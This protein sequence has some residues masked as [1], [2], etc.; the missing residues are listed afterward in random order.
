[1]VRP[2][3]F[4]MANPYAPLLGRA[5]LI[6]VCAL[7]ASL[8]AQPTYAVPPAMLL[9]GLAALSSVPLPKSIPTL[10][11]PVAEALVAPAIIGALGMRGELF[12]PY[13]LAPIVITG[14]L[15]GARIAAVTAVASTAMLVIGASASSSAGSQL[16]AATDAA[17]WGPMVLAV[18]LL[19]A[20]SRRIR[21]PAEPSVEP[22]YAD[23]HRLLSELHV[24]ARHLS[25]G[26]DPQ[27][28]ARALLEEIS[29]A[30][31]AR[32][33]TVLVRSPG[34]L[35]VPLVG[36]EPPPDAQSAVHDAWITGETVRRSKREA[37][38]VAM[39]VMMGVRVVALVVLIL[40]RGKE[41]FDDAAMRGCQSA[42]ERSGPRL[43]T[44]MLFDDVRRL[45]TEDERVRVAREIHD[46]IAQ[47][48]AS[49]GYLVDD[50]A[51][52]ADEG[53]SKRLAELRE[54][55]GTM[56]TELRLSI[57]DLR[58]G[59]DDSLGLG[60]AV[61]E[62]VQRVG[63]QS[64][65]VVH[66][67]LDEAPHRLPTAVEVELLRILQEAVTNVRRHARASNLWL[68]LIV[69]PP[70]ARLAIADDGR[71]LQSPRPDSMGI[72]GMQE[73]ARRIG[74]RL[75][76]GPSEFGGTL[77]EVVVD[78]IGSQQ[79]AGRPIVAAH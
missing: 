44:A 60:T 12:R 5:C 24:V 2:R 52:D 77:V 21:R 42:V 30:V 7:L 26:L 69:D 1:M 37:T 35:F 46:G 56:V 74:G 51:Q 28:L 14:V 67:L 23:A 62:Y 31:E 47:D 41:T 38:V 16:S 10:L 15:G 20:W 45:A 8:K 72:T 17:A 40:T 73:R 43:A 58:T 34:G 27:T 18:G 70:R 65:L 63:S 68:T 75:H 78:G 39:P 76:I 29:T 50:I 57:F 59:V 36:E 13:L 32:A 53:T 64:G 49:V 4:T 48:L 25:L 66:V 9:L 6:L 33:A 55:L 79:T 22:A 19:A 61:S 3:L 71:G 54:H 11:Q